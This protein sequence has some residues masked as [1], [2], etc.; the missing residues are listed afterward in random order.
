[1]N[2]EW[3]YKCLL[4][5]CLSFTFVF[6][7]CFFCLKIPA[8]KTLDSYRIARKIMAFNYLT[9]GLFNLIELLHFSVERDIS[10]SALITVCV[11]ASQAILFTATLISLI[12]IK[13]ISFRTLF[14]EF[15]P[16]IVLTLI[17][18]ASF[19]LNERQF[20]NPIYYLFTLY[21]LNL[22]IRY[23]ITF[24]KYYR[25][26]QEKM[27]NF[28]SVQSSNLLTWVK[29]AYYVAMSIG[30]VVLVSLYL[31]ETF[32]MLSNVLYIIYFFYF[33]IHFLNYAS[34]FEEIETAIVS[35]SKDMIEDKSLKISFSQLEQAVKEWEMKKS[36]TESGITIEQ[37]AG[38][39]KTNRTYLSNYL[40]TYKGFTFNEWIN[41]LRIEEAKNLLITNPRLPVSQIGVMIGLPDKSNFGRQFS[42]M[43]GK[44]PLAW[45]TNQQKQ[46]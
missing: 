25:S 37:V 35:D 30:I 41:Q 7:L 16:V 22:L 21:Y 11:A 1:M 23:S 29:T 14:K 34:I 18:F 42:K 20:F 9:I 32:V 31:G 4:I 33:G 27:D 40:N 6:S 17:S 28:F 44:S 19:F 8:K 24:R 15:I 46:Y 5:C 12:N 3:T 2:V 26:Y 36:Y 10:F 45:R 39:I 13:F 38:E 43:T